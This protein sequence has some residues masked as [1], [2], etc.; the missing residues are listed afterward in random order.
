M[1]AKSFPPEVLR[2]VEVAVAS[3]R[4]ESLLAVREGFVRYFHKGLDRP[5]PVAAVPQEVED[6]LRGLESTDDGMV[7]RCLERTRELESRL[8]DAYQFYVGV[9]EGLETLTVA[10]EPR[11]Y[12]RTWAVVRG[13][14]THACGGSGSLE[15]PSRMLEEGIADPG[16]RLHAAGLRRREGLVSALSSGLESRRGAVAVAVFN[17]LASLFFDF[18]SGHPRS[19]N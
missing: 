9:E 1:K 18:Y 17:A 5:V 3:S 7:A 12:V 2:G 14:G 13:L 10:G 8:G 15:V 6:V 4:S 16:G 19:A 11:H